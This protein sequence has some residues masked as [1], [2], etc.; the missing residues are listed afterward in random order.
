MKKI[1]FVLVVLSASILSCMSVAVP[2]QD[3]NEIVQATF[4]AQF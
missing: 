3:V 4:Q 1:G 2:T